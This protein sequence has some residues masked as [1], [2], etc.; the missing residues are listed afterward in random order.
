ML[1]KT[2]LVVRDA[3]SLLWLT[4][5]TCYRCA[6]LATIG[7]TTVQMLAPLHVAVIACYL[8]L[9]APFADCL[10]SGR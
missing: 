6:A 9:T 8:Q 3:F 2:A 1:V 4:M 7:M 10:D 5:G